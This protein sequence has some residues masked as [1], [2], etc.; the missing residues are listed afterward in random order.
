M[1]KYLM[2]KL[3]YRHADIFRL[4][5]LIFTS[6]NLKRSEKAISLDSKLSKSCKHEF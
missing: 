1:L 5:F 2:D 4:N 3:I 6:N